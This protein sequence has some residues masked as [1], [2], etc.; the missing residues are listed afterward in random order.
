[1]LRPSRSAGDG[2]LLE[3]GAD[4]EP[5]DYTTCIPGWPLQHSVVYAHFTCF[6]ELIRG[7]ALP[8]LTSVSFPLKEA[9][10]ARL[11]VPHA[12]L[13]YAKDYPE[14]IRLYHEAGGNLCQ[15]N[16]SGV[17]PLE[18]NFE[19]S[20]AKDALASFTGLPLSLKSLCRLSVR[21]H[22]TKKRLHRIPCL[23]IPSSLIPFLKFEEFNVYTIR[24]KENTH[25]KIL[26]KEE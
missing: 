15:A 8:N 5:F 23:G 26:E 6:L 19:S 1:M 14:F 7:G 2:L 3:Y 4:T 10:I 16:T 21:R 20:P 18:A 13:K 17:P 25:E 24:T 9:V 22:L 11:S 12:V